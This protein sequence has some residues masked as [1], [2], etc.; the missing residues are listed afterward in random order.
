MQKKWGEYLFL[1]IVLSPVLLC[2]LEPSFL[3]ERTMFNFFKMIRENVKTAI[4][5][6]INDAAEEINDRIKDKTMEEGLPW[7]ELEEPAEDKKK[8]KK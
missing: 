6:G 8:S 3:G 7:L 1:V 5:G 2:E 4:L